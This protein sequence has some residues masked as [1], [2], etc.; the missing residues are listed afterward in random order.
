[1][2]NNKSMTIKI[3]YNGPFINHQTAPLSFN[4]TI[5]NIAVAQLAARHEVAELHEH[6]NLRTIKIEAPSNKM[7]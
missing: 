2:F 3:S 7:R 4:Q 1:M 6:F 5:R